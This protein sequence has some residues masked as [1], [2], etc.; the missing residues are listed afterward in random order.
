[1][2]LSKTSLCS[3]LIPKKRHHFLPRPS[4]HRPNLK[5]TMSLPHLFMMIP[6]RQI[7]TSHSIPLLPPLQLRLPQLFFLHPFIQTPPSRIPPSHLILSNAT[8]FQPSIS[9]RY[10]SLMLSFLL[11]LLPLANLPSL[12]R[13]LLLLVGLVTAASSSSHFAGLS[14]VL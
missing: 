14:E 2:T 7:V 6:Q 12:L 3:P 13:K 4:T 11:R 10:H 8:I 9:L 1:M 5:L